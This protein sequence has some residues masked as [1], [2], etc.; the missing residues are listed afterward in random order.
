MYGRRES[1][2]NV[3]DRVR[4]GHLWRRI[5]VEGALMGRQE[6]WKK[7]EGQQ[8]WRSNIERGHEKGRE[9]AKGKEGG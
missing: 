4:R 5:R 9:R 3:E 1:Q 8:W 2:I 6:R 7:E